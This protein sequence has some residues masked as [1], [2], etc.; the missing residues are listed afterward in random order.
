M[1]STTIAVVLSVIALSA[2]LAVAAPSLEPR[3]SWFGSSGISASVNWFTRRDCQNPCVEI[4]FCTGN[5]HTGI[6]PGS[7]SEWDGGDSGGSGCFD[8]PSSANSLALSVNNGHAFHAVN[9]SCKEYEAA[10]AKKQWG[11]TSKMMMG[12]KL[13]V[14]KYASGKDKGS[15][16]C[17]VFDGG[18]AKAVVY[19]W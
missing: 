12:K 7:Y 5:E 14:A 4:G 11:K 18:E 17:N 13:D 19:H 8:R 3:D 16:H 10:A 6:M 15:H 2:N 9:V 1:H